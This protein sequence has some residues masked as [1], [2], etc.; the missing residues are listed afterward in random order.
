MTIWGEP[1]ETAWID[2]DGERQQV[3]TFP[4]TGEPTL[5]FW[6]RHKARV[7]A[8]IEPLLCQCAAYTES[9]GLPGG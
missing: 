8:E 3:T 7:M 6:D 1:A 9:T 2:L 5:A 4:R